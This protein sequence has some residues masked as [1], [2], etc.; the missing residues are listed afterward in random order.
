MKTAIKYVVLTA[1]A[2][3]LLVA[4][5]GGGANNSSTPAT[6]ASVSTFAGTGSPGSTDGASTLAQFN[7][8][9][10]VALDSVGNVYV[11]DSQNSTIR[12]IT[13]SGVVSTIA[14]TAGLIGTTDATGSSA[15]FDFPLGIAVE[16]SGALWITDSVRHT[17]RKISSTGVVTTLAGQPG[18]PGATD[19]TGTSAR[20]NGPKGIGLDSFGDAYVADHVNHTIRKITST[21]VV[22]TFAGVAG[23]A[24][25]TD[26][27]GTSARF[28]SPSGVAVD[29]AGNCYV[30]DTSNHVIRKI[31]STGAVT[32]FAGTAGVIGSTDATGASARFNY[33]SGIA[34]D[35]NGYV[36][37]GDHFNHTIRKITPTGT[38]ST[39]AGAAGLIGSINATGGSARFNYPYGLAVDPNGNIFVADVENHSIRKIAMQP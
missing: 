21:G 26:A 23:S 24:G 14:G 32:T 5:G 13:P 2:V 8:P 31:T 17:I 11:A 15:R 9:Y 33:P 19:A 7:R 39:L 22:T 4:C 25:S 18:S 20:F 28:N 35:S 34:V 16:A 30:A 37:V 29:S 10:G 1:T 6:N 12:K 36:Y 3:S 27:T 38:V